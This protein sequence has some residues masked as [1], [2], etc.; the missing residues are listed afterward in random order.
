MAD[1]SLTC[2]GDEWWYYGTIANTCLVLYVIGIPFSQGM[3]LYVYRSLLYASYKHTQKERK[4][5]RW[6]EN[7][8]GSIYSHYREECYYF[9][10][11]DIFRRLILILFFFQG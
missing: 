3:L 11:I 6:I 8:L 9:E 10:L 7:S 4:A 1:Y 2:F 5:R